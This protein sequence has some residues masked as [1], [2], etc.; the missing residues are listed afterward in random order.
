MEPT[1][2]S[3]LPPGVNTPAP[4]PAPAAAAPPP[5]PPA[6][7][8]AL[9]PP[10]KWDWLQIG[11]FT[12]LGVLTCFSIYYFRYKTRQMPDTLADQASKI[13]SLERKVDMMYSEQAA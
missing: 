5:P 8:P 9:P 2:D 1:P 11:V 10:E 12:A 3:G 7:A 13:S 4:A 6:P